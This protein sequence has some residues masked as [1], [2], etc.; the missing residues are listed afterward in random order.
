MQTN[1]SDNRKGAKAQ[2]KAVKNFR[3]GFPFAR[4]LRLCAFAVQFFC[5]IIDVRFAATA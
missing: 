2:R 1:K 3:L 5:I 4:P